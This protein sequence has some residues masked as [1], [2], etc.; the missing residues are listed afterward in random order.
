M[1]FQ[2]RVPNE[3]LLTWNPKDGWGPI[4]KFLGKE[5]PQKEFPWLNQSKKEEV[6][7]EHDWW[8]STK[9]HKNVIF[10]FLALLF[11]LILKNLL[12]LW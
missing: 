10:T 3:R 4:C 9:R 8:I 6:W 2:S 5:R 1:Y 12:N 11:S 7:N